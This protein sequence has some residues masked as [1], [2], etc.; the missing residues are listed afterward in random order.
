MTIQR[1]ESQIIKLE[2]RSQRYFFM[3]DETA[4]MAEAAARGRWYAM[5]PRVCA[6]SEKWQ[7]IWGAECNAH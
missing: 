6:T 7:A 2:S 5:G 1:I 3:R 4:E